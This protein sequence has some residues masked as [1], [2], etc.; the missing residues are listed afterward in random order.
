MEQVQ[1]QQ[2]KPSNLFCSQYYSFHFNVFHV[3]VKL[4]VKAVTSASRDIFQVV[5]FLSFSRYLLYVYLGIVLNFQMRVRLCGFTNKGVI[6][7]FYLGCQKH[8]I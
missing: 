3:F 4:M 6:S 5:K 1:A 7:F 2:M 8:S